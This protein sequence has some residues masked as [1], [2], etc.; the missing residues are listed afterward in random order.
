VGKK[1]EEGTNRMNEG[2][3]GNLILSDFSF[4]MDSYPRIHP[5]EQI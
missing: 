1:I 4:I 2:G 3:K 5:G